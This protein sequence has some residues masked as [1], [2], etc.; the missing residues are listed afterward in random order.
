MKKILF[1]SSLFFLLF[2]FSAKV[3]SQSSPNLFLGQD[4]YYS[5]N[6][7]GNG[8]AI[9]TLKT[10][11]MNTGDKA[12][13]TI[14]LIIPKVKPQDI[15]AYQVIR[16]PQCIRYNLQTPFLQGR[17]MPPTCLEYGEADYFQYLGTAKYQQAKYKIDGE[18][19]TIN[20]PIAVEPNKSG[21]FILYYRAGGYAMSNFLGKY[22]FVFET[23]KATDKT[24]NLQVGINVDS[25]LYLAGGK[26]RVNYQIKNFG[27]ALRAAPTLAEPVQ[28]SQLDSFYQQI[29]QGQIIKNATDLQ[30]LESYSV[31][32]SFAD[33]QWKIYGK[34]IIAGIIIA[35]A[36]IIVL[37]KLAKLLASKVSEAK[38]KTAQ[39]QNHIVLVVVTSL[40]SSFLILGYTI[41]I[42]FLTA[43][44]NNIGTFDSFVGLFVLFLILISVGVYIGLLVG[45][46]L[47]VGVKK[48]WGWGVAVFFATIF[49]LFIYFVIIVGILLIFSA[50]GTQG[51]PVVTPFMKGIA[52]SL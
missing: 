52:P 6:F 2:F 51:Q 39:P 30:P 29:G 37:L 21:S 16:G 35:I 27:T 44:I 9:V 41:G 4:N 34:Q 23:L 10:V 1:F 33:S 36:A 18:K 20:L 49:W 46:A 38:P 3:Y 22:N 28:N 25:D 8:E 12:L 15:L 42:I 19:I 31:K 17:I 14:D 47:L 45:P 48:G 5:V 24:R 26:G 13:S 7:R 40:V 11:F 50:T 43:L 32:G